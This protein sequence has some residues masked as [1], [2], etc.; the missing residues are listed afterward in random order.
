MHIL[1]DRAQ[2]TEGEK[3]MVLGNKSVDTSNKC[4][5]NLYQYI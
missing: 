5:R 1:L 4:V 3:R 2:I